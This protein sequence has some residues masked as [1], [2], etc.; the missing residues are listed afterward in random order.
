MMVLRL[1]FLGGHPHHGTMVKMQ[2]LDLRDSTRDLFYE[3]FSLKKLTSLSQ[4]S[5]WRRT[6]E[7]R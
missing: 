3:V 2:E 6:G 1:C 4:Q 7:N 5:S